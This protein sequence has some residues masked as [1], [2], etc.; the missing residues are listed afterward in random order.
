[1][2]HAYASNTIPIYFGNDKVL[3]DGF[4]PKSFINCHDYDSIDDIVNV[5]IKIDKDDELYKQMIAEPIFVNNELPKYFNH[6][7]VFNFIEKIINN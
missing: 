6:E 5:I 7:Y 1:M 2:I 4:N 3:E